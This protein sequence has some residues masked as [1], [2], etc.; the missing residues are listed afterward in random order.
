MFWIE[1]LGWAAAG[2]TLCAYSMRTMLPLRMVAIGANILFIAYGSLAGIYPNLVLHL[3]L[4]PFNV[5]RLVEI[6]RMTKRV[7]RARNGE[8][9][10]AWIPQ[11]LPARAFADGATL[12]RKGDVPDS[13]FY[14]VSGRVRL[15]EIDVT[16]DS[17][18]LF[19]E[20]AF[21]S[22][23]KER[24]LTAVCDGRCE[25]VSIDERSFMRLYYQN[26]AFG[27]YI[28][29]L[30]S[31]RLLEGMSRNPGAYAPTEAR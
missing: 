3:L 31:R 20:I 8:F 16:L 1:L 4:L 26:P 11:L 7:R 6:Q 14:L 19:G 25:I 12:F 9:D 30:I 2:L 10:P 29:R 28:V 5:W 18:E 13:L 27:M 22:D 24:T 15:T 17:G 23:A 21:F